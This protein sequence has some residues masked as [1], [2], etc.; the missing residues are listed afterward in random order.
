MA[1]KI[2]ALLGFVCFTA[3]MPERLLAQEYPADVSRG[4]ALY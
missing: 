1:I 4:K 2:A 3:A